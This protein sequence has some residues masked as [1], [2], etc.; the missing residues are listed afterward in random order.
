VA[1]V[2]AAMAMAGC[3]LGA[4]GPS[5]PTC[6]NGDVLILIAQSV[7]TAT[8]LPCIAEY[9]TGWTF[10][11][12]Q[13]ETG[14][15]RF[16]LDSDRA[17]KRAV[18]VTL[19]RSCTTTGAVRVPVQPDEAGTVRYEA[20]DTLPPRFTGTRLYT[21]RGGCVTYRFAFGP[22]SSFTQAI[23][24]TSALTFFPRAKGVRILRR[25]GLDLCGAGVSCP[26]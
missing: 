15:A 12:E 26:G 3:S 23:E 22:R 11:G 10:G 8:L 24:A 9:P 20:P 16:W 7:P 1:V 5:A 6:S 14:R 25:L 18:T 2:A 17:G 13:V 4:P 21:F 19:T